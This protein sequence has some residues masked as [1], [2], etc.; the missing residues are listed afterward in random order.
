DIPRHVL[1]RV[2]RGVGLAKGAFGELGQPGRI[3]PNRWSDHDRQL[4]PCSRIRYTTQCCEPGTM[5]GARASEWG[6]NWGADIP[7]SAAS[8]SA[9]VSK[10]YSSTMCEADGP[11]TPQSSRA[12]RARRNSEVANFSAPQ[13]RM[14]ARASAWFPYGMSRCHWQTNT[15]DL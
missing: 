15:R 3:A 7:A 12:P 11:S 10:R 2:V 4:G 8:K 1:G 14:T 9:S 6:R 5:N 13:A